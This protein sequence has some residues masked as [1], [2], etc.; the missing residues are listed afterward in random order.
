MVRIE[1][2][3]YFDLR[4]AG[5]TLKELLVL[6]PWP[7]VDAKAFRESVSVGGQARETGIGPSAADTPPY[8]DAESAQ[9]RS[10]RLNGQE[11]PLTEIPSCIPVDD[12]RRSS[13]AHPREIS[14]PRLRV[15]LRVPRS[16]ERAR[17]AYPPLLRWLPDDET[18]AHPFRHHDPRRF[19]G[20]VPGTST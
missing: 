11:K 13:R 12:H 3:D 20:P 15:V 9:D 2:R 5:V 18:V 14:T 10:A 4:A 7:C 6:P 8:F 17:R 1:L 16:R 19:T